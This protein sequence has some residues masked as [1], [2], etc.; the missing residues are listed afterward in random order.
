M[1][2]SAFFAGMKPSFRNLATLEVVVNVGEHQ[3]EA[4]G[5]AWFAYDSTAYLYYISIIVTSWR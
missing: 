4:N 1:L 2:N 5:I 3:T